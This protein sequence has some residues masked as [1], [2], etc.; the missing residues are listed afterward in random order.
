[1]IEL[2]VESHYCIHYVWFITKV[3]ISFLDPN[4]LYCYFIMTVR[5]KRMRSLQKKF[6][7]WQN[8][9]KE[10]V[11]HPVA[12]HSSINQSCHYGLVILSF[13]TDSCSVIEIIL[14]CCMCTMNHWDVE[15]PNGVLKISSILC[16]K[17]YIV[18]KNYTFMD[19]CLCK[20]TK[21]ALCKWGVLNFR[22]F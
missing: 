3:S 6:K 9:V 11:G 2:K 5:N 20:V 8:Q 7:S 13:P 14:S 18:G 21:Q 19:F 10:V 4:V 15:L 16:L 1:M 22:E 17:I 12:Q